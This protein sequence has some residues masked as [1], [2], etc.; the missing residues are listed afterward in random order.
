MLPHLDTIWVCLRSIRPG[1]RVDS[2][3]RFMDM[4]ESRWRA[5]RLLA[6]NLFGVVPNG[7]LNWSEILQYTNRMEALRGQGVKVTTNTTPYR[8]DCF[9]I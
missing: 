1:S 4:L 9:W 2:S 7:Y 5:D 8:D 6:V 3:S